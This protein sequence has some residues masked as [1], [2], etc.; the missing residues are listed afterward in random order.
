[1]GRVRPSW[2]CNSHPILLEN[3]AITKIE[4]KP[5]GAVVKGL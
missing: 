3:T 4:A 5:A 2:R 1:M